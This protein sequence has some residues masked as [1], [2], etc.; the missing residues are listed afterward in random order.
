[1]NI[2]QGERGGNGDN[3][4]VVNQWFLFGAPLPPHG[5]VQL[6]AEGVFSG[7]IAVVNNLGIT[8]KTK[9]TSINASLK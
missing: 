9:F 7:I 2:S 5:S 6:I 3:L 8:L 1:M 4:G